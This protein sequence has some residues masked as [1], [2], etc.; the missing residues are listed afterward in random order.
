MRSRDIVLMLKRAFDMFASLVGLMLISP[1][2]LVLALVV[3]LDSPGP[4][5]F[6]QKRVGKRGVP[7]RIRKFRTMYVPTRP[8]L[9]LTAG[10]DPRI[11][12]V[13]RFLRRYKFDE[14]PQL[15]DVLQGTMS[16]VGPRP[17]VP[18][19]IAMYPESSRATI[20]SVRPGITDIASISF[21]HE[22]DILAVAEDPERTYLEQI[23]PIKIR[24]CEQYVRE[25]SFPSDFSILFKTIAAIC[26]P[27]RLPNL[28]PQEKSSL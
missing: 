10:A 14:L 11:T 20:L 3:K 8:G 17:E 22:S 26:S 13:G 25:R 9:E 23:L 18:K 5:L 12:R 2:L 21:R 1:V 4:V 27:Q 6:R 24:L 28:A 16:L 7:F 15:I 19:Y